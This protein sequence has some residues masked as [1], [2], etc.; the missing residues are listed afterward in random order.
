MR[1]AAPGPP[2]AARADPVA[3]PGTHPAR[4]SDGIQVRGEEGIRWVQVPGPGGVTSSPRLDLRLCTCQRGRD[5]S[6]APCAAAGVKAFVYLS[7]PSSQEEEEASSDPRERSGLRIWEFILPALPGTPRF[8]LPPGVPRA[9][10]GLN[11]GLG[12]LQGA[13]SG[14]RE[15]G[16]RQEGGPSFCRLHPLPWTGVGAVRSWPQVGP[17]TRSKGS[18]LPLAGQGEARCYCVA[19]K[20]CAIGTTRHPANRCS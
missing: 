19:G 11:G 18:E 4:R 3:L 17:R 13:E 5:T 6:L 8:P 12:T 10:Q 16:G 9:G 2:D 15:A 20:P 14:L 1:P 7:R